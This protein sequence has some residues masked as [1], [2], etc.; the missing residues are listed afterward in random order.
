MSKAAKK[1]S[2]VDCALTGTALLQSPYFNKGSAFP[3]NERR[4]FKL[5]GLLPSNIQ[6][7]EEQ[8]DRAYKQFKN[9]D[10]PLAKNTFMSSL[11]NQNTVLYYKLIQEHIKELFSIIYTPTEGEAI[12]NFSG[13]FRK[14]EGCFLNIFEQDKIDNNLAQ[15][16]LAEDIDY[17][18]VTDG[19]EIL[20]IGD[21]GVGAILISVA[22]L[23]LATLCAGVHPNRTLP[24][25]LDCGTD[26]STLLNDD[27]YLGIRHPRVRGKNYDAFVDTFVQSARRLYPKAYIHF[28]DFG[29]GNARRILETYRPH[30]AVF[31][32][33]VQGTGCVTLAAVISGLHLID[34]R[35]A[36]SRIVI[37]GAGSAGCGIADQIQRAISAESGTSNGDAA[38]Q[39]W[40]VDKPG[41]LLRSHGDDLTSAQ[42]PYARDDSEWTNKR[43][44]DLLSVIKEIKPH[45]LI[46]TSTQSKVFSESVVKEMARHTSRPLIFPLSN[47]TKLQEAD[48]KDINQW[49]EGRALIATGSPCPPV[50]YDGTKY[51]VA[52]C[53]N[54]VCFPGIGLGV[55]LS[56]ARLLSDKMLY[57]A[58][59]ALASRSPALQ[60]PKAG[61]LP[62][63]TDV[64]ELSVF[65]AMAVIKQAVKEG[66]AQVEKIPNQNSDLELWVREQMWEP[67]YRELRFVESNHAD[68]KAKDEMG[69]AAVN[70]PGR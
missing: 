37:F 67:I 65:I 61:L 41:L 70:R 44:D 62:D 10:D 25:V 32:D 7:L 40:C 54:S 66:L 38:K 34:T 47:P 13:L 46:G 3:A 36:A 17:I 4:I 58:A 53:N 45:V 52:E 60:D 22:K 1:S 42:V 16:G 63:V 35:L 26:N 68:R 24:V 39:I 56:H 12:Q 69:V 55:I 27:L 8:V 6:T 23:V 59:K 21:Q 51:E 19:E 20:G 29:L 2:T 49:T 31:N 15:W 30:L 9:Q 64:R 33:D 43:H 5:E 57:A 11:K 50:E 14:P 48:P 28:E 18:V